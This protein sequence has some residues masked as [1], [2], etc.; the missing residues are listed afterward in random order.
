M[1]N[2]SRVEEALLESERQR[3]QAQRLEAM[4][5]LAGG[6]AHDFNNILGAILGYGEMA[7]RNSRKGSRLRRDLDNI[8]LAAERGR[9]LVDGILAFSRSGVAERIS[10]H[11]EE[12]VREALDLLS[13]KLPPG[14]TIGARLSAAHAA[15]LGDA[16]QVHQVVMNLATNGVQ[17]MTAGGVL[18]VSL[19]TARYDAPRVA[20]IGSISAGD[21]VVLEVADGGTGIAPEALDRIFDPFFTTKRV[22][23]GT[24]LGLSLVHGIVTEVGGAIDV[25]STSGKG[26]VFTVYFPRHGDAV[27]IARDTLSAVPNGNGQHVMVVDDE[28][29]LVNLATRTRRTG[30]HGCWLHFRFRCSRS[31]TR[32][33]GTLRCADHGRPHAWIV[34]LRTDPRGPCNSTF[35]SNRAGDGLYRWSGGEPRLQ[36]GRHGAAQEAVFRSGADS[37]ARTC[38]G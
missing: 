13:G 8:V 12:V 24:G 36:F 29:P 18:C 27:D 4:G 22:S 15:M 33:P 14:I 7:L 19:S 23:V 26:S 1:T 31:V 37:H 17:A 20:N 34:R 11:V 30:L 21:Y 10:V 2:C 35:D 25:S 6:I 5:M 9:A 28:E 32:R 3:R 38:A 16:T